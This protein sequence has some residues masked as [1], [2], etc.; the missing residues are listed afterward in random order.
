[1]AKHASLPLG[2]FVAGILFS[3][4]AFAGSYWTQFLLFNE[5][6]SVAPNG[7]HMIAVFATVL[8]AALSVTCFASGAFS[9]L[10]V[11]SRYGVGSSPMLPAAVHESSAG[12]H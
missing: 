7:R 11:L 9:S 10:H 12:R 2:F 4:L 1:M 6:V 8:M 3:L 5:A